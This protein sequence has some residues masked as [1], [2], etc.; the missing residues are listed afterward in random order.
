[1]KTF[2]AQA[3]IPVRGGDYHDVVALHPSGPRFSIQKS[4]AGSEPLPRHH[5][6]TFG[7]GGPTLLVQGG[8]ASTPAVH[9]ARLTPEMQDDHADK[10]AALHGLADAALS[11]GTGGVGFVGRVSFKN[12]AVPLLERAG[13]KTLMTAFELLGE[14][15]KAAKGGKDLGLRDWVTIGFPIG[16]NKKSPL[17]QKTLDVLVG[18]NG[19]NASNLYETAKKFREAKEIELAYKAIDA[20]V[21]RTMPNKQIQPPPPIVVHDDLFDDVGTSVQ[22]S[23]ER[24]IDRF[25]KRRNAKLEAYQN[26]LVTLDKAGLPTGLKGDTY[27]A[28]NLW[29]DLEQVQKALAASSNFPARQKVA[30][31]LEKEVADLSNLDS[32]LKLIL[33]WLRN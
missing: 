9:T 14:A 15:G 8:E 25:L 1:M 27:N 7:D 22:A 29:S 16:W 11:I 18:A 3:H 24:R 33:H 28:L 26:A 19:K 5:S 10:Q 21:D 17:F 13:V 23:R 4:P 6:V 2:G 32:G 30:A 20:W 31:T 12:V